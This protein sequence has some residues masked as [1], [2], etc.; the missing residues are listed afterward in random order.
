MITEKDVRDE[1]VAEFS[2]RSSAQWWRMLTAIYLH[3]GI[4]DCVLI[5]L[6]QIWVSWS[7]ENSQGWLRMALLHHTVG[8]EG[9]LVS[10]T[11]LLSP[12]SGCN[13][14]LATYLSFKFLADCVFVH[15]AS[16]SASRRR[17]FC[18][19]RYRPCTC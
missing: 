3:Q 18:G 5:T 9:H 6:L 19:W 17:S 14:V 15:R 16:L 12:L 10:N 4:L 2:P 1:H 11:I 7:Q 8:V 13:K